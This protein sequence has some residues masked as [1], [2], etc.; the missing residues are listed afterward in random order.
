MIPVDTALGCVK[1]VGRVR[2]GRGQ[3]GRVDQVIEGYELRV[4]DVID[5]WWRPNRDQ[6]VALAPY[7][8][9]LECLRGARV[10]EFALWR[11]GMTIPAGE[12]YVLRSRAEAQGEG[13]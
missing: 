6:V 12:T 2:E 4:G 13:R 9:P 8:G 5:V 7:V 11:G 3:E 1:R 10:A